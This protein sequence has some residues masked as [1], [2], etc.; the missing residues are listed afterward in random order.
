VLKSVPNA[1]RFPAVG[2]GTVISGNVA[3]NAIQNSIFWVTSSISENY[4]KPFQNTTKKLDAIA[5]L[6]LTK[7]LL[8]KL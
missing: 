7:V 2:F 8:Q 6:V 3:I 5:L 1:T 4:S